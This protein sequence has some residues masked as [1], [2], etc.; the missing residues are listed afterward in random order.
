MCE[1]LW[2]LRPSFVRSPLSSGGTPTKVTVSRT[3]TLARPDLGLSTQPSRPPLRPRTAAS[4]KGC[5]SSKRPEWALSGRSCPRRAYGRC[6]ERADVRA[7]GPNSREG[8]TPARMIQVKRTAALLLPVTAA[9]RRTSPMVARSE[10]LWDI[11]SMIR[12]S[13]IGGFGTLA[14]SSGPNAR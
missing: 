7:R 8:S 2:S 14:G 3:A 10:G 6:V 4:E 9:P 12:R 13:E 11:Q 1:Q 5:L